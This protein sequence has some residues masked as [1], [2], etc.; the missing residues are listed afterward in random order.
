MARTWSSGSPDRIPPAFD[1]C[2]TTVYGG[3][4]KLGHKSAKCCVGYFVGLLPPPN[5]QTAAA[6]ASTERNK[7]HF[8]LRILFQI[9]LRA[10]RQTNWI[11]QVCALDV[12]DFRLSQGIMGFHPQL[13][14]FRIL[15]ISW[16][17]NSCI[18]G[19]FRPASRTFQV[20]LWCEPVSSHAKTQ[21]VAAHTPFD[22]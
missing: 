22:S 17:T 18:P 8:S 19:H 21:E 10:P 5:S 6:N 14:R 11:A 15:A 2:T 13:C 12:I 9:S 3:S 16:E 20:P 1:A 7:P 4:C